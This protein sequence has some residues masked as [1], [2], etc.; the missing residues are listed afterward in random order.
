[1]KKPSL[2]DLRENYTKS[3]LNVIDV[4]PDPFTQFQ[5]WMDLAISS[6]IVDPNAM[7]LATANAHGIPSSRIVLLKHY[8]EEGFCFFT[9]YKSRKGADLAENPH[10]S[11][12]LHWKELERQ[13]CI[14]GRVEKTSHE[15]SE[16][17]F[18][19]RPHHSQIGALASEQSKRVANRA[20]LEKR[21]EELLEKYPAGST[22]PL[23]EFWGGYRLIPD[24]IEFWQGRPSR[25]HDRIIY[26]REG[27][28][29]LWHISRICP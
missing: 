29:E 16:T 26:T 23:P 12:V 1:M 7:T 10:A 17:Y 27:A 6:D 11:I 8:D 24:Y 22:I 19:M 4:N 2:A 25:L 20:K 28:S 9:N 15:E 13:I 14:R 5:N 18:Q 3:G 21:E